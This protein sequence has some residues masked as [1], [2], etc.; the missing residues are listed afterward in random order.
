MQYTNKLNFPQYIVDWLVHDD[1]DHNSNPYT[2]SATTI[3]KPT[4]S[5]ILTMRHADTLQQD[6]SDLIA[7]RIGTAIHDSIERIESE[8]VTKELRLHRK[9][10]IENIEYTVSGKFD[11]LVTDNNQVATLRDIKT[12]SVWSYVF[13][14]KDLDY[15]LQLSIYRWLLLGSDY[16]VNTVGYIDFF[17]TDWQSMKARQDNKYPQKKI[18]AGYEIELMSSDEVEAYIQERLSK[19]ENNLQK[20]DNELDLCTKKELWAGE[21]VFAIY[22]NTSSRAAKL[23]KSYEEA[24]KYKQDKKIDGRIERRPPKVRRCSYCA[25]FPFCNQGQELN[26]LN[27]LA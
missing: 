3:M 14:S 23:C 4:R 6:A 2:I 8:N 5:H 13:G 21:E 9:I 24:I 26:R 19:L 27:L 1:Y 16:K 10:Q 25:A 7:S 17:F 12:T 20:D 15:K 18:L 11:I 22:R